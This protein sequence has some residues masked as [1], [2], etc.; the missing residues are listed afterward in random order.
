V[1]SLQQAH[2]VQVAM[3]LTKFI[4]PAKESAEINVSNLDQDV[5][6]K[7]TQGPAFELDKEVKDLLIVKVKQALK[8][9]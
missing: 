5:F 3:N 9:A 8:A 1:D 2:I 4:N 7:F 6:N